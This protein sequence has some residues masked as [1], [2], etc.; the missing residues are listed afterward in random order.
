MVAINI[1]DENSEVDK[2]WNKERFT[3]PVAY[4]GDKI[5]EK[6]NAVTP[7][8]YLIVSDGKIVKAKI[9]FHEAELLKSLA[10]LGVQ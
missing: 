4:K 7:T 10:D 5:G 6:Y 1:G 3:I 2:V 9:V 8:N